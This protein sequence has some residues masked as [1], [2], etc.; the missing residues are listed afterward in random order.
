MQVHFLNAVTFLLFNIVV[1]RYAAVK[2]LNI[3]NYYDNYELKYMIFITT[4]EII[5]GRINFPIVGNCIS[6]P[7]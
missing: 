1:P 4:D 2:V 3:G 5:S 7:H 6:K